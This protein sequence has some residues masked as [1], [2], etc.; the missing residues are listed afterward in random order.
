MIKPT[1][2]FVVFWILFGKKLARYIF[3]KNIWFEPPIGTP[4]GRVISG[5][6]LVG[7]SVVTSLGHFFGSWVTIFDWFASNK[8]KSY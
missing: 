3:V 6:L 2:N 8:S 7:L 5:Y 4:T 1:R